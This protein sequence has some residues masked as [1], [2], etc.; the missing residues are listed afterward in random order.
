MHVWCLC[1]RGAPDAASHHFGRCQ[2]DASGESISNNLKSSP[3]E[4][5]KNK[6]LF[7][8]SSCTA[9]VITPNYDL[10]DIANRSYPVFR[11]MIPAKASL[12]SGRCYQ[13]KPNCVLKDIANLS[14]PVFRQM[15]PA[16]ASLCSDRCLQQK[17]NCVL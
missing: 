15:S 6:K 14:Y 3:L 10:G 5:I 2:A 4:G 11:Q 13:R 8:S 9:P 1:T 17:L 12:C 7:F 16:E